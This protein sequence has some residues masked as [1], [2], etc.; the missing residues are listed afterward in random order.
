MASYIAYNR[1]LSTSA[2]IQLNNEPHFVTREP[3]KYGAEFLE[4][5]SKHTQ[6][7]KETLQNRYS[8][9]YEERTSTSSL[10]LSNH[11]MTLISESE[12][13]LLLNKCQDSGNVV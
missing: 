6:R 13:R 2:N 1:G 11:G 7:S 10:G 4:P 5:I 8:I 3:R 12:D 9:F